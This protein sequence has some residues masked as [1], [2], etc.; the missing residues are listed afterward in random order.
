MLTAR[1]EEADRVAGLEAG[2]D[3][4]IT[5]PFSPRELVA[6]L[7]AVLRRRAPEHGGEVMEIGGVRLDPAAVAV[8]VDGEA[9]TLGPTE[10]KL[11]RLFL[12][13]PGR[14]FSRGQL[15]DQVWGDHR[16]VEERTVDVFIR[17]LRVALGARGE[18]LVQT[19]RGVGYRFAGRTQ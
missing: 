15:L 3:D 13:Q 8:T 12:A 10:F 1:G 17:R 2:A 19:V 7:R 5:K 11:L 9:R 16:F 14:A 6:R 4:Y 18:D